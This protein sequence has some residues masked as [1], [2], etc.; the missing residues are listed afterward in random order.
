MIPSFASPGFML[1]GGVG[2]GGG[3]Q[4]SKKFVVFHRSFTPVSHLR[5]YS[6]TDLNAFIAIIFA[7]SGTSGTEV[8]KL[9]S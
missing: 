1:M 9:H 3:H 8:F 5:I 2:G 6:N 4:V 7:F